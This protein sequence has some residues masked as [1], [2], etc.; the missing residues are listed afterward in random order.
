M[1]RI[2]KIILAVAALV[3]SEP[4]LTSAVG[5]AVLG[6]GSSLLTVGT[7]E[8]GIFLAALSAVV[9]L[10]GGAVTRG[11]VWTSASVQKAV[12]QA[13]VATVRQ[14]LKV[15]AHAPGCMDKGVSK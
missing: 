7:T 13:V 10:A 14:N 6:S 12:E 8:H 2:A 1:N 9:A 4:A 5:V 11:K 15:V 3:R